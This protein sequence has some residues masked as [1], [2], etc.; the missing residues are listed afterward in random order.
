MKSK[1][2][3]RFKA[4]R[5]VVCLLLFLTLCVDLG[6][7]FRKNKDTEFTFLLPAGATECFFQT[8]T[9]TGSLEVEYQVIAGSGL[10]VG[11]TLIS[12]SGYRLVSDFRKS[13]GIHTV[14]PAEEGDYRICFDNSF[15]RR[16][17]K[18]VYVEVIVDGPEEEADDEED[19]AAL[20]E[21]EDSLEYKLEDIRDTMDAVHKNLERS[22]QMQATLRAFEA[23]DR[24]LLEDNL[25]RVSF[26]SSVSLL[27]MVSVALTQVYTVRRLFSDSRRVCT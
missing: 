1:V 7:E 8:A 15:N 24:Y 3:E 16:S 5:L 27:V 13:D 23:R 4:T 22:R 19:W 14:D 18:M 25:W 2:M 6:Y 26:W 12:P 20:A 10:D 11:F 21:P 17:E 9:K